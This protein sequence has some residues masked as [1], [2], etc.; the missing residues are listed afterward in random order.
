MLDLGMAVLALFEARS[1]EGFDDLARFAGLFMAAISLV[2]V[3][4]VALAIRHF[5]VDAWS[6]VLAALVGPPIL[7]ALALLVLRVIG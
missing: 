5:V 6:Q 3:G 2:L 7:G 4:V 1:E